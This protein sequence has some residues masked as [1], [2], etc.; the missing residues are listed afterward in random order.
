MFLSNA[1]IKNKVKSIIADDVDN[2]IIF[3]VGNKGIGKTQLLHE[4][5][6]ETAFN[7]DVI[8]TDGKRISSNTSN[9]AKCFIEGI[10]KYIERNNRKQI[11]QKLCDIIKG[12]NIGFSDR[13]VFA[14]RKKLNFTPL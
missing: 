9:L 8:V 13:F 3:I 7:R 14:H 12:G 4:L 11:R 1:E 5:Y 6:G 2:D 10:T